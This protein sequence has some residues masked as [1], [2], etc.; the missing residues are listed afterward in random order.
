[1][2]SPTKLDPLV[3]QV[4]F[5]YTAVLICRRI[6]GSVFSERRAD[7]GFQVNLR[8]YLTSHLKRQK[9]VAGEAPLSSERPPPGR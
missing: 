2:H 3:H 9:L 1:M 8:K 5:R 7:P 6:G 4:E